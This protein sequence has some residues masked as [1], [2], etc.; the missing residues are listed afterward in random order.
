LRLCW[1]APLILI[2]SAGILT[3]RVEP[4]SQ[5]RPP[6]FSSEKGLMKVKS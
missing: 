1:R 4:N 3:T 2:A 6:F 5:A